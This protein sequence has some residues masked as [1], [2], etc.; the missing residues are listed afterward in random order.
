[1]LS[2][3]SLFW[4]RDRLLSDS[5]IA[6]MYQRTSLSRTELQFHGAKRDWIPGDKQKF[7]RS[8]DEI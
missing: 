3:R 4:T 6:K 8:A 1:M 7:S 2:I 5:D